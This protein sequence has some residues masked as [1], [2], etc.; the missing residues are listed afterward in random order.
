[1]GMAACR[2]M[3]NGRLRMRCRHTGMAIPPARGRAHVGALACAPKTLC[4]IGSHSLYTHT[5]VS[6]QVSCRCLVHV[7]R[8]WPSKI[9]CMGRYRLS[10]YMF[11]KLVQHDVCSPCDCRVSHV[12]E[13]TFQQLRETTEQVAWLCHR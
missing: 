3:A 13:E 10:I 8:D 9:M 1:M 4:C 6:T 11:S 5:C 2:W 12:L 7:L